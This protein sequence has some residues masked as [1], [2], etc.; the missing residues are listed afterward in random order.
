MPVEAPEGTIARKVPTSVVR[1]TSTVGLPRESSTYK[2]KKGIQCCIRVDMR[3][4]D[5]LLSTHTTHSNRRRSGKLATSRATTAWIPPPPPRRRRASLPRMAAEEREAEAD[6]AASM[7]RAGLR[8]AAWLR[9]CGSGGGRAGGLG[10][11]EGRRKRETSGKCQ[12]T[13]DDKMRALEFCNFMRIIPARK[14]GNLSAKH[15]FCQKQNGD[16]SLLRRQRP[17]DYP[18]PLFKPAATNLA[19]PGK[20]RNATPRDLLCAPPS[21]S[22]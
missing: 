14:R 11:R 15:L 16:A 5:K 1:S 20:T 13:I 4:R 22:G 3:N 21:I 12:Q 19:R 10:G 18:Q 17:K 8:L 7:A 9:Q 6:L 2:K